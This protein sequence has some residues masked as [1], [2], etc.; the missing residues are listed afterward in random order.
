MDST[1]ASP[2]EGTPAADGARPPAGPARPAD[3]LIAALGHDLRSPLNG[4]V[5]MAD[6][7][8]GTRLDAEQQG[9]VDALQRSADEMIEV[10]DALLDLS[11][12]D[13]G[14]LEL[15]R[16]PF[17]PQRVARDAVDRLRPRADR[18]GL[19]LSL[20]LRDLPER[21]VGDA[22]RLGQ[23]LTRLVSHAIAATPRG[24]VR[25][26][27]GAR[28]APDG[29]WRLSGRVDDTGATSDGARRTWPGAPA[30][31][32]VPEPAL[33]EGMSG[34]PL[35]VS[36]RLLGLMGGSLTL[37]GGRGEPCRFRFDAVFDAEPPPVATARPEGIGGLSVLVVDDD[38]VSRTLALSVLGRLGIA[39][40]IAHDG[41]E[42]LVEMLSNRFDVVIMDVRMPGLDGLGA[43][44]AIRALPLEVRQPWIVALTAELEPEDR[45]RCREAGM[46]DFIAK[47]FRPETL[48]SALE[49][50]LARSTRAG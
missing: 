6:L 16:A 42:A 44:R 37:E 43:T 17:S 12:V 24:E 23:V 38:A 40:R 46:D 7:L 14:R 29:R 30:D 41:R 1:H 49:R 13:A 5:G 26:D 4:V 8:R 19:V 31:A 3:T 50:G 10:V 34:V 18:A 21:V 39:A 47:P 22:A 15:A 9:F 33:R 25:L 20:W 11:Q 48:R 32:A 28:R 45:R 36:A 2:D 35:A 27:L